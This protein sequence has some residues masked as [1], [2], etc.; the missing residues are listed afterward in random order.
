M[1]RGKTH[2]CD[3]LVVEPRERRRSDSVCGR[4]EDTTGKNRGAPPCAHTERH[5]R[6]RRRVG[7]RRW[8]APARGVGTSAVR[9]RRSMCAVHCFFFFKVAPYWP[10]HRL[11]WGFTQGPAWWF[12]C[13][14]WAET[15]VIGSQHIG[16][17]KLGMGPRASNRF[18]RRSVS[19]VS[20][21]GTALAQEPYKFCRSHR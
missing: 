4:I 9:S 14:D 3:K 12:N 21:G 7:R 13:S 1:L 16:A 8:G 5:T 15:S 11:I 19:A 10:R 20:G 6:A 18:R 17:P 2:T